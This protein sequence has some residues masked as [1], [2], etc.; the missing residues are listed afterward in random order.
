MLQHDPEDDTQSLNVL[1]LH[2]SGRTYLNL[3]RLFLDSFKLMIK[4]LSVET[5]T[6]LK[7]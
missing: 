7:L 1:A 5:S 3:L 4:A 2:I 6:R